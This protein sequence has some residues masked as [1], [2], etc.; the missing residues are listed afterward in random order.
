MTRLMQYMM[1]PT[2][3]RMISVS[4][5]SHSRS[6]ALPSKFG[7]GEAGRGSSLYQSEEDADAQGIREVKKLSK[8]RESAPDHAQMNTTSVSVW[9]SLPD[10]RQ[11][12]SGRPKYSS[13]QMSCQVW[14]EKCERGASTYVDCY[15]HVHD[16]E[17]RED[18]NQCSRTVG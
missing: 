11:S 9:K 10:V 13:C 7:S 15:K 5:S 18:D 17:R 8:Q 3:T 2:P 12:P 14:V 4:W 16:G 6:P 1:S